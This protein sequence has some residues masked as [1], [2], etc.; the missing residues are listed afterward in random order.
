MG[1][2]MC[3][4]DR[5]NRVTMT[6]SGHRVVAHDRPFDLA[7]GAHTSPRGIVLLF[8]L[9]AALLVAPQTLT[10]PYQGWSLP[11][12]DEGG[13]H[14]SHATQIT[15]EN[16]TDLKIAWTHR[17]GDFREGENFIGGLS[18]EAPLQSSWQATPVLIEDHLYLCTPFNEFSRF[19][20]K[21]APSAGPTSPTSIWKAF[22]CHAVAA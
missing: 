15:P 11:G 13:G 12:A 3:I 19:M 8:A 22:L 10:A 4:R 9:L 5:V 16:V 7:A 2:E 18:G 14:F 21:P 17:S 6:S 1:S 20:P